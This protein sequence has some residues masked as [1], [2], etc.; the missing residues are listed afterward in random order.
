MREKKEK[1]IRKEAKRK[2]LVRQYIIDDYHLY[3]R[4]KNKKYTGKATK[5]GE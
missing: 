5:K 4:I 3:H 1:Q 2:S